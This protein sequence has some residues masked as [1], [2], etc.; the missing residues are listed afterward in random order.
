M[1]KPGSMLYHDNINALK[2]LSNEELGRLFMAILEY[3][4][5][6][7]LPQ[8]EGALAMAWAFIKPKLD[9]D[10]QR[11]KDT[12]AR[13]TYAAFCRE[14]KK[15]GLA[16]VSREAW[17]DMSI[18]E[19]HQLLSS[20]VTGYPTTDPTTNTDVSI[21]ASASTIPPVVA[22]IL[23]QGRIS[24]TPFEIETLQSK[25]GIDDLEIYLVRLNHHI[26]NYGEPL[27]S[28]YLTILGW[29]DDAHRNRL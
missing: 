23:A 8:F 22:D 16:K 12:V 9:R 4:R 2:H 14:V 29:W 5:D 17:D 1:A 20:D 28:H 13:S 24:L 26:A 6:G 15:R 21:S 27:Q 18:D 7:T 11:Y 10:D 25:M 19:R 3:G